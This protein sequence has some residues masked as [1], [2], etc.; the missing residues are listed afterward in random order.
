MFPTTPIIVGGV[1]PFHLLADRIIGGPI[2]LCHRFVDDY[3]RCVLLT[4]RFRKGPAELEWDTKNP[5]EIAA[6]SL[7]GYYDG[8]CR[9]VRYIYYQAH[10]DTS[11]RNTC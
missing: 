6:Y 1:D 3:Y 8:I 7:E 10:F 11:Q 2:F 9:P 4:I 5:E